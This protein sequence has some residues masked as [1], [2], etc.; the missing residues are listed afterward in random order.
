MVLQRFEE[1]TALITGGGGMGRAVALRLL[2]E[3]V[4]RRCGNRQRR[5]HTEHQNEGGIFLE[6][7]IR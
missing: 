5:T 6:E 1:K 2:S 3:A 7:A 4:D